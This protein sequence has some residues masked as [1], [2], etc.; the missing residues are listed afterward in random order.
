MLGIVERPKGATRIGPKLHDGPPVQSGY[1]AQLK[2]E[3]GIAGAQGEA[4]EGF[5]ASLSANARR[6]GAAESNTEDDVTD[7]AFGELQDRLTARAAMLRAATELLAVLGPRQQ[8][9]ATRS[10]PM[11]CLP[12]HIFRTL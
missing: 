3:L 2:R 7:L 4:W 11:C 8:R 12:P 6:M 9:R 10:L 1:V 5:A